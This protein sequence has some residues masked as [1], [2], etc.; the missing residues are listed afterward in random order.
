MNRK[1]LQETI[2]SFNKEEERFKSLK[3]GQS[4]FETDCADPFGMS[5]FKHEIVSVDMDE[6]FVITKDHSL[7]GRE[8]KLYSFMLGS[9]IGIPD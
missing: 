5:Y 3:I 4:V 7:G 2:E 6:F 1:Q 9:E 8:S